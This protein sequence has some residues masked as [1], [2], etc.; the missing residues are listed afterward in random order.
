M[1]KP[2]ED[3]NALLINVFPIAGAPRTNAYDF[4]LT[5]YC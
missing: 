3:S 4:L 1:I 5:K 2:Y